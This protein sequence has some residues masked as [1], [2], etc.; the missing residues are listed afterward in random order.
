MNVL[1]PELVLHGDGDPFVFEVAVRD[2]ARVVALAAAEVDVEV[3]A[4]GTGEGFDEVVGEVGGGG[5]GDYCWEG[6]CGGDGLRRVVCI[7]GI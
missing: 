2:D 4:V 7:D 3:G 6:S 1:A 5:G